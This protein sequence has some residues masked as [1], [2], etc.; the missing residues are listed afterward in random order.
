MRSNLIVYVL[1]GGIFCLTA[2]L[3][4]EF[5]L[6][7][8]TDDS[9]S[10][11]VAPTARS[12]ES[13]REERFELEANTTSPSKNEL[14]DSVW[15]DESFS[16]RNSK[17]RFGRDLAQFAEVRAT[18][19][20]LQ[21]QLNKGDWQSVELELKRLLEKDPNIP[22]YQAML[23]DYY[24]LLEQYGDA[25][26]PVRKLMELDSSN[27]YA[28]IT[29]ADIVSVNGKPDE[30]LSLI[31]EV[32]REQPDNSLALR[33]L[34]STSAMKGPEELA[35]AEEKLKDLWMQN[36][37]NINAGSELVSHF[38]SRGQM[39]EA[40]EIAEEIKRFDPESVAAQK[41]LAKLASAQFKQQEW[42]SHA[43]QWVD[44]E[45]SFEAQKTLFQALSANDLYDEALRIGAEL[46]SRDQEVA[47]SMRVIRMRSNNQP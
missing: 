13:R 24:L 43:R 14:Q 21:E 16:G 9:L 41:T 45:P 27:L 15:A 22:E 33:G 44:L 31:D 12:L 23:G 17:D 30:A 47:S 35:R 29:L 5:F 4:Y 26:E 10:S 1:V 46:E 2:Y 19:N 20:R 34:L 7:D 28:K 42:L 38:I 18:T 6:S 11:S 3:S 40:E 32:L 25:E 39:N 37:D 36:A 8:E